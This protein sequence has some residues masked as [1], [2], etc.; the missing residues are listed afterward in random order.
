[1]RRTE[2]ESDDRAGGEGAQAQIGGGFD[3][4]IAFGAGIQAD[5]L[6]RF[7]GVGGKESQACGGRHVKTRAIDRY[8]G[9]VGIWIR[10]QPLDGCLARIHRQDGETVI[11][12]STHSP[13]PK[14]AP[15]LR[16][17]EDCDSGLRHLEMEI[18]IKVARGGWEA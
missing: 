14:F 11:D 17:A 7:G 5:F 6:R 12:I 16:S 3:Q 1:M 8:G 18:F 13:V 2:T 4:R 15:I 10:H 9:H